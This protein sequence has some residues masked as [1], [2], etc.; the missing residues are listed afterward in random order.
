MKRYFDKIIVL[1]NPISTGD[2]KANAKE[3]VGALRGMAPNFDIELHKTQHKRH[4]EEIAAKYSAK[5]GKW[6]IVSSSGDGG[7]NEVIN[8]IFAGSQS[9]TVVASVLPSGNANDHHA[10][11]SSD[12]LLQNIVQANIESIDVIQVKSIVNGKP[13]V[14][15][16]HSYT[17]IGITPKVGR[18][19]TIRQL[20]AFNEKW[21]VLKYLLAFKHV[22]LEIDGKRRRYSSIVF[23]TIPKMSKVIKLADDARQDDGRME[24]YLS[25]YRSF[26]GVLQLLLTASVKGLKQNRRLR[27]YQLRTTKPTLIQ[28]DGEVTKLDAKVDVTVTCLKQKL[29]TIV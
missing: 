28:L 9:G 22:V 3:F 16:A 27:R 8:G 19:L 5:K 12:N 25:E 10:A 29:R 11:M 4:A 23:A 13:W 15:Y 17:G 2:S 20:N 7:Y 18:E 24:V 6:L 1:Y 26:F 21:Y 14:R